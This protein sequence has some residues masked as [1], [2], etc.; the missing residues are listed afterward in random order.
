MKKTFIPALATL[1][2]IVCNACNSKT[3]KGS[4]TPETTATITLPK[5]LSYNIINVYPHDTGSYTEGL[6]WHNGALY[7]SGGNYGTSKL[8]KVSLKDGKDLQRINL[9]KQYFGEGIT[10]FNNKLYQLTY[11]ENKCF[12]YDFATFNKLKEFDYDGEGW[13]LTNNGKVLI[14][15]NGSD[16][17]YFRDP[18]TFKVLNIVSVSDNNGPL[19]NLNELEYVD[20]FIYANIYT[21][22]RIVKIDPSSGK[23][24][25]EADMSDLITKYISPY[26]TPEEINYN[27][28]LNGIAYDSTGKRFFITGKL[29][30]KLFEVK[31][32]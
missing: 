16:K 26:F 19:A 5:S 11:K 24:V 23:V 25:A 9:A 28:V 32:N 22:Q 15:D 14:M 6:E 21:T 30:P 10:V 4:D 7:E 8:A 1:L 20:G 3:D 13:S 31:F 17:L 27:A 2:L 12:V 29:W 18:E